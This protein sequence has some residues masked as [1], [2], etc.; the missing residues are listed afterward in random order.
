MTTKEK[1]QELL[2]KFCYAI[3][4]EEDNEGYFTNVKHAKEC[5]LIAIEEI[6]DALCEYHLDSE[7]WHEV[8]HEIEKL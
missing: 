3:R 8:K 2:N 4:T 5:A 7:W 6:L 1:A